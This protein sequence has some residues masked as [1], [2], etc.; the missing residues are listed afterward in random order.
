MTPAG[1]PAWSRAAAIG[2]YG[3]ALD[4]RASDTEGSAP[5]A[6]F[7]YCELRNLRG[8]AYSKQL[9]GTLVHCENLAAA[10]V[11]AYRCFRA[12]EKFAC[13][14]Q[15]PATSDEGLPYWVKVL[16]VPSSP[17]DQKWQLRQRCAAHFKASAELNLATIRTALQDLLGDVYVDA[18]FTEGTDLANPPTQT[19]WPGVN[20]GDPLTDLGGGAWS[21]ER[22]HLWVQVQQPPGM[23]LGEY[24]QL[25]NVQGVQLLD[26]ILPAYCTFTLSEPGGFDLDIDPLDY[27]GL[28]PS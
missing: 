1:K 7:V 12:P 24:T 15:Q 9:G 6:W 11:L 10:R 2:D 23:T 28:T 16:A 20:P 18:S 26:R 5:Y 22:S 17:T 3:G 14:A 21:S 27:T 25:I 8:S 4:K 13:N 19:F